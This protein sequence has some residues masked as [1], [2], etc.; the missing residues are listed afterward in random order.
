MFQTLKVYL[1]KHANKRIEQRVHKKN[2]LK[3]AYD[4]FC[5]GETLPPGLINVYNHKMFEMKAGQQIKIYKEH[6]YIFEVKKKEKQ[7]RYYTVAKMISVV[8]IRT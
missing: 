3:V 8:P 2:A 6:A 7:G 1:T 5:K 4:A